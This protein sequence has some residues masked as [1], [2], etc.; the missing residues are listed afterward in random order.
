MCRRECAPEISTLFLR[1]AVLAPDLRR[2]VRSSRQAIVIRLRMDSS[3]PSQ[4]SLHPQ[5][6]IRRSVC[7]VL[8]LLMLFRLPKPSQDP[9]A[10][11]AGWLVE[12]ETPLVGWDIERRSL[13]A[14]GTADESRAVELV[15]KAVGGLH[16]AVH[17]K[18]KM[19]QRA[20]AGMNVGR[21]EVKLLQGHNGA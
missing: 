2:N 3:E 13:F 8:S 21:E 4:S 10:S 5:L 11:P 6:T 16:C 17:L 20:I 18:M 7:V 12:V 9:A 19:S 15:R 14:V 1:A